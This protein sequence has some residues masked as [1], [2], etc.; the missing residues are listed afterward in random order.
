M[1]RPRNR[2][3]WMMA[4]TSTALLVLTVA[5]WVWSEIETVALWLPSPLEWEHSATLW[6]GGFD[7]SWYA[8]PEGLMG[9]MGGPQPRGFEL[10]RTPASSRYFPVTRA[11][12]PTWRGGSSFGCFGQSSSLDVRIP[13]WMPMLLLA[14]T[15]PVSWRSLVRSLQGGCTKCHYNLRGLPKDGTVVRNA[16][17]ALLA[18]GRPRTDRRNQRHLCRGCW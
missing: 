2:L 1:K 5:A 18:R 14:M 3:W 8:C 7:Y 12:V 9:A 6:R 10:Y 13:L 16:V 11:V 4:L 15:T 17:R